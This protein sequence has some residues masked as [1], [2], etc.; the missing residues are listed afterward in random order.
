MESHILK[1]RGIKD[2]AFLDPVSIN[3]KTLQDPGTAHYLYGAF[4]KLKMKKSI[5]IAYN[6]KSHY[7]L[8]DIC[9]LESSIK[10][11]D[12]KNRHLSMLDPLIQLLNYAFGIYC[13][14]KENKGMHRPFCKT[15]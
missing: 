8:L 3:E 9:I 2:I 6:C 14:K 11:Y 15:F 5:L 4:C 10:V 12:S 13:N 7:V 1:E